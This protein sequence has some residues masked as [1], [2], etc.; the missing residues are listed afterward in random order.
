MIF[1]TEIPKHG[2]KGL[3]VMEKA[4]KFRRDIGNRFYPV[5]VMEGLIQATKSELE[6][7]H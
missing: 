4:T 1:I 6:F 2:T 3:S 7:G 5:Y